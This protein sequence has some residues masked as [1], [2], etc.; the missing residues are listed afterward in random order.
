MNRIKLL[1]LDLSPI[2]N[3]G[4][5]LERI[6]KSS[7]QL[8]VDFLKQSVH[9]WQT[10]SFERNFSN[11]TTRFNPDLIILILS[12]DSLKQSD[13]LLG[14]MGHKSLRLPI[15]AFF[16]NENSSDMMTMMLKFST[17][18]I[19]P[20]PLTTANIIPIVL[21]LVAQTYPEKITQDL[22]QDNFISKQLVGKSVGFLEEINKIPTI[23]KCDSNVLISGEAGTGKEVCARNIHYLSRRANYPFVA[24]NCD[25]I[26]VR[27]ADVELFGHWDGGLDGSRP[28]KPG[29]ISDAAGGTL[30]L[31]EIN[32]LCPHLQVKLLRFLREK[33]HRPQGPADKCHSDL[34]I[35]AAT[36]MDGQ[37]AVRS[38]KLRHDLYATLNTI[39]LKLLPLRERRKDILHLCR[40]LL[41]RYSLELSKQVLGF[42]TNALQKLVFYHWPGNIR[43]LEHVIERAV[44]FAENNIISESDICLPNL[45]DIEDNRLFDRGLNL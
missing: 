27:Q 18:D 21:W 20:G 35:I 4:R 30:F 7:L 3:L 25:G 44:V 45:Q 33:A 29:L 16:E 40:H 41:Y 23:A 15:M 8:R 6:L 14:Q 24:F 12:S 11:I 43:E 37:E 39:S 9:V 28:L 17:V 10:S 26:P 13:V 2:G 38:G 42:S 5:N 22:F 19:I 1:I 34:R 36:S 31:D 32:G